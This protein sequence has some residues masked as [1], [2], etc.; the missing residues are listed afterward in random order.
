MN[1]RKLTSLISA[2][3]VVFG[4]AILMTL[5][6]VPA[7]HGVADPVTVL[8]SDQIQGDNYGHQA[9]AN[10]QGFITI[11]PNR[12]FFQFPNGQPF[13]PVGHNEMFDQSLLLDPDK[14]DDYF[15]HMSENG[16]N[17]LRILLDGWGNSLV[18]TSVGQF[19]PVVDEV[20]DNLVNAAEKHGIYLIISLWISIH[21]HC[22][23][24]GFAQAWSNHP[25]N[26]AQPGG[27][28]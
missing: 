7:A 10:S 15:R 16:E 6:A 17:V 5:A 26:I 3:F 19:S 18:E 28:V 25:Y 1:G 14:L 24:P 4:G 8:N 13:V 27:L 23:T 20:V 22:L 9:T 11:S 12:K 2:A 21:E